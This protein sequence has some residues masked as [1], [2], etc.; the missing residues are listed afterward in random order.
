MGGSMLR[1][2]LYAVLAVVFFI[3]LSYAEWVNGYT[4]SDGTYVSGYSR[5]DANS[6]VQDNYSYKGNNNPST[7]ETGT[8][9]YRNN[10]T[11]EYYGTTP[12]RHKSSG[13]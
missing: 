11:S 4:R 9:Y 13:W 2:L 10:P 5:S 3:S 7:G 6:T 12:K 1:S 8:N